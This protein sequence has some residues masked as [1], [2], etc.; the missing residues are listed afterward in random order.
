MLPLVFH[1]KRLLQTKYNVLMDFRFANGMY[2][3]WFDEQFQIKPIASTSLFVLIL[4]QFVV[5]F[6]VCND[7]FNNYLCKLYLM[8]VV[9]A[10]VYAINCAM[11]IR[12]SGMR[13][14]RWVRLWN[15]F[16]LLVFSKRHKRSTHKLNVLNHSTTYTMYTIA[17]CTNLQFISI[18][19]FICMLY[20]CIHTGES[21]I[22]WGECICIST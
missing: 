11:N 6:S 13:V 15:L 18:Y 9:C 12:Q 20:A 10:L 3:M 17:I 14:R 19:T 21:V 1:T 4:V 16:I 7:S 8:L 5:K 22:S 2:E